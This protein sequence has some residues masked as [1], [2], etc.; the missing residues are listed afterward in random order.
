[1][2][3]KVEGLNPANFSVEKRYSFSSIGSSIRR[4]KQCDQ[5]WR[6]KLLI[7]KLLAIFEGLF[8]IGPNFEPTLGKFYA[9]FWARVSLL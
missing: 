1:M 5:I 8:S 7:F 2:G 4:C 9:T 6:E 3:R